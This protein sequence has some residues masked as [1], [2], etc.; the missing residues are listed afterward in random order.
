MTQRVYGLVEDELVSLL[1]EKAGE[2]KLSRA[3][4]IRL[5]IESYLHRG[6]EQDTI[7]AVNLRTEAVNLRA[8]AVKLRT[9]FDEQGQEIVHLKDTLAVKD[10]ELDR[11]KPQIEQVPQMWEELRSLRSVNS[12]IKKELEDLKSANAKLK[13][14]LAKRQIEADQARSEAEVFKVKLESHQ[15]ALRVKDDEVAFLRATVHQLSE[16]RAL[17]PS[18]EEIRA[19]HWWQFW[20]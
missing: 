11:L 12:Q 15:S 20:R 5:A 9:A 10:G 1:D 14:E 19:K 17:P 8:E 2:A 7:E 4:W 16:K 18:E 13:D 3:Q 6:G